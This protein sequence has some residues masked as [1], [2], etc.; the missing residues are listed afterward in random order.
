MHPYWLPDSESTEG[1]LDFTS[2]LGYRVKDSRMVRLGPFE[3]GDY[4]LVT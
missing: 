2:S 1:I 3:I 4:V